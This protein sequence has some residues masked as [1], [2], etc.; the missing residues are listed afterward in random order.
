MSLE[1]KIAESKRRKPIAVSLLNDGD[2][3]K[4]H[5]RFQNIVAFYSSGEINQPAY[6]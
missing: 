4:A 5:K 6:D 2:L 1:E 3:K